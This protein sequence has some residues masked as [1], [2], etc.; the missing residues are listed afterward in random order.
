MR[1]SGDVWTVTS[2]PLT[3]DIYSYQFTV[4]GKTFND[5][6]NPRFIEEFDG[7]RTSTFSVQ[8]AVWTTTGAPE[9][10]I[11]RHS[12]PSSAIGGIEEYYVY[13]PPGY[14]AKRQ[15]PYPAVYL[16]HGMGDSARTW[17]TNGGVDITLNNL[18]AQG[19]ARPMVVVMPLGYGDPT[20][21]LKLQNFERALIEEMIPQ[22]ETGYHLSR[23]RTGRAIAGV[24]MGGAQAMSIGLGHPET[25]ASIGS[26]SGAF[27]MAPLAP[28]QDPAS[29]VLRP[30]RFDLIYVGWGAA[31]SLAPLNRELTANLAARGVAVTRVEVPNAGHVWPLWRQM[32]GEMLRLV[33]QTRAQ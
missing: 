8:G 15:E 29:P 21:L 5:P 23:S 12:Y 6:V 24:S 20:G 25:F 32:V 1:K 2:Q 11:T 13:A 30:G 28:F 31:D 22:A 4:D 9:G 10:A 33:F 3:P 16:L 17:I 7:V 18:I 26:F 27:Q 19:R 14:D